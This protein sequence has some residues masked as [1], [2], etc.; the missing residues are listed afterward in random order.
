MLDGKYS[1]LI[2]NFNKLILVRNV[3][4]EI[5]GLDKQLQLQ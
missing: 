4:V 2:T 3:L 1:N 5:F